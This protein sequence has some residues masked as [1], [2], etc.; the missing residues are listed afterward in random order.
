MILTYVGISRFLYRLHIAADANFR[1]K[2]R[3]KPGTRPDPGLGTG[4]AYFIENEEY[5]KFLLNYVSEKDVSCSLAL[6]AHELI[7]PV[8]RFLHAAVLQHLISPTRESP[9]D[10]ALRE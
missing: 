5:K 2:N 7:I 6:P 10:F 9:P 8:I 3:F 1:M 4:W